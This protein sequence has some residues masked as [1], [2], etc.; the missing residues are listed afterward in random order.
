MALCRDVLPLLELLALQGDVAVLLLLRHRLQELAQPKALG[1][2]R[3]QR[4]EDELHPHLAKLGKRQRIGIFE[5]LER[6]R[7][8]EGEAGVGKALADRPGEG[9]DRTAFRGGELA[10]EQVRDAG[11]Q[12]AQAAIDGQV[13]LAQRLRGVD[14]AQPVGAGDDDEI[15]IAQI[16]GNRARHAQLAHHLAHRDQRLAPDVPAAFGQDLVFDVGCRHAGVDVELGRPLDIEDVAVPTVHVDNHRRD[17]QVLGLDAL[18]RISHRHRQLELAQRAHRA[19][20]PIRDLNAAVQVHVGGA[21]VA[22]GE[23]IAAEVDRLEAVVHDELGAHRVVYARPEQEW[24][25]VK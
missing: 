22:Y 1:V 18:F 4:D 8:V 13:H 23:R 19:P 12:V 7:P 11:V 20:R 9:F 2:L 5:P 14:G 3:P 17:V 24:L 25:G 21:Q 16:I 15:A 6:G 10:P